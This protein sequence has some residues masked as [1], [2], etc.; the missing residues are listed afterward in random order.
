[1]N[2]LHRN[3]LIILLAGL[4]G[5]L[6]SCKAQYHIERMA[7]HQQKAINKGA[8]FTNDTTVIHDTITEVKTFTRNDTVFIEKVVTLTEYITTEGEIR[9]ITKK[10]KRKE[11]KEEKKEAKHERKEE[12]KKAKRDYKIEKK[13]AKKSY[14]YVWLPVLAALLYI[15]YLHHKR[16]N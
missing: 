14:W 11:R 2:R 13:K 12:K 10:D 7:K 6:A 8:T 9:Y 15:V 4:V 1:M 16:K 3:L 5:C